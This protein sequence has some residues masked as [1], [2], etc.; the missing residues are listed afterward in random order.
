MG[1]CGCGLTRQP[2]HGRNRPDGDRM[3]HSQ[4]QALPVMEMGGCGCGHGQGNGGA[5]ASCRKLLEQIRAV[6][7]A[8]YEVVLYLDVYPHSCD[9]LET[10]HKLKAQ[11]EALRK[12]Y[13]SI[14]G[15]LTAFGNESGASWDW[16]AS[17]FPWEYGAE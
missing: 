7:F 8:L 17:P 15:P 4:H 5:S 6:D 13:E 16:I 14:C 10:Y 9:A 11:R 1:G 2:G 3:P 12:E